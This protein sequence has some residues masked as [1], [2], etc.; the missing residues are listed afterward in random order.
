MP[1]LV[2]NLLVQLVLL[3]R[4]IIVQL[5][6]LVVS[7]FNGCAHLLSLL[8]HILHRTAHVSECT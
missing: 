5:V 3:V 6:L 2:A 7:L 4:D 8:L 1:H